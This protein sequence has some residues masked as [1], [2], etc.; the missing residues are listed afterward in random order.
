[1]RTVDAGGNREVFA[2]A[3]EA[4]FENFAAAA[5]NLRDRNLAEL[6]KKIARSWQVP[7]RGGNILTDDKAPVELL[8]MR[9]LDAIIQRELK[10]YK[11]LDF[12]ELLD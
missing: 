11:Q 10:N 9:A 3:D 12:R 5:E 6:M 4:V 1:M 2:A 8:G 7:E